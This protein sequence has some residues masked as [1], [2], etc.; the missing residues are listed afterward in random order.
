MGNDLKANI[1]TFE[2]NL[3][4]CSVVTFNPDRWAVL[5]KEKKKRFTRTN[6][7]FVKI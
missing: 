6:N 7:A 4:Q 2:L 3:D 5:K 1:T